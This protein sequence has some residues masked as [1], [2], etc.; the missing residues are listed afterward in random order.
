MMAERLCDLCGAGGALPCSTY[1]PEKGIEKPFVGVLCGMCHHG[2][3]KK[4]PTLAPAPVA[5][6]PAVA[7]RLRPAPPV[8]K[9][10]RL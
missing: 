8:W 3:P 10:I 1:Y 5:S 4:T 9:G 7:P 2:G 6:A